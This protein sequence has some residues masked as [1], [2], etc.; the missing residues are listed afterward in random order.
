MSAASVR[1]ERREVA[2]IQCKQREAARRKGEMAFFSVRL[3]C[4]FFSRRK[5]ALNRSFRRRAAQKAPRA[6]QKR[7]ERLKRATS[8]S[9]RHE[10]LNAPRAAQRRH[11]Q[12]KRATSGSKAPR[13][14]KK[15]AIRDSK[16]ALLVQQRSLAHG[17]FINLP[18]L[19]SRPAPR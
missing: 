19:Q 11:E 8:G 3:G 2:E 14:A 18:S 7:H 10:R 13:D 1:C 5:R 15:I 4:L 16:R 6:A 17:A 9:T 12:L